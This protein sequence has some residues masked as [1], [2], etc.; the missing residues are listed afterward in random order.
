M[1]SL[2]RTYSSTA[3]AID[4]AID[5]FLK[6]NPVDSCLKWINYEDRLTSW[7]YETEAFFHSDDYVFLATEEDIFIT[8]DNLLEYYNIEQLALESSHEILDFIDDRFEK[9][10]EESTAAHF[11]LRDD[12]FLTAICKQCGQAGFQ[13]SEFNLYNSKEEYFAQLIKS[14]YIFRNDSFDSHSHEELISMFARNVTKKYIADGAQQ[15]KS[16]KNPTT[17]S[18]ATLSPELEARR[19][20][21]RAAMA[22]GIRNMGRDSSSIELKPILSPQ[23]NQEDSFD[24]LTYATVV[25]V[26]MPM[27]EAMLEALTLLEARYVLRSSVSHEEVLAFLAEKN[28]SVPFRP[29]YL[30]PL[31]LVEN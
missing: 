19:K 4:E 23:N 20:Q 2:E 22:E 21:F 9:L 29:E 7:A 26:D 5:N 3:E 24:G 6:G 17:P 11:C 8:Q 10:H 25:N 14:G 16:T 31:N 12:I 13:F 15:E 1:T 27:P 30:I 18:M 28:I